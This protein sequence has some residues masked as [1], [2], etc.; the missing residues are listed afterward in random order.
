MLKK[1]KA[2]QPDAV[3]VERIPAWDTLSMKY[4]YSRF[5][6]SEISKKQ[7]LCHSESI[8]VCL[9]NMRHTLRIATSHADGNR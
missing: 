1:A 2:Y 3:Y 7:F 5:C 6:A 9:H 8:G 4:Y